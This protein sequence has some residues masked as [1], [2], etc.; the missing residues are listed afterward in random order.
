MGFFEALLGALEPVQHL[1]TGG[2][3]SCFGFVFQ[4]PSPPGYSVLQLPGGK[5]AIGPPKP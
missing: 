2:L 5:L 3:A 4:P 1:K